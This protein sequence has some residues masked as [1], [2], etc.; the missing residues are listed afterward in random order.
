MI[1]IQADGWT[2]ERM[3][4]NIIRMYESASDDQRRRGES[5]Y[6][7]AHEVA[8]MLS[9]GHVRVGAGLLAALS[10]QTS[11]ES[12]IE[13]AR[14]AYKTGNPRDHTREALA[15]AAKILAGADP[16]EVLPMTKKTGHFF[17]CIVDPSD[18]DAVCIDRHAHDLAVGEA[19]GSKPR[20]LS[21]KGRYA[22][23]AHVYREAA[24]RL[25]VLPS[26][27]QAVTWVA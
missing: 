23:L 15:K 1:P 13:L 27:V 9:D 11:W 4:D 12:S 24:Q 2:R 16:T 5:W 8:D 3:V 19:Y 26:V 25:G 6:T 17:R 10:P 7:T 18:P 20:G 22:L 21:A 14:D